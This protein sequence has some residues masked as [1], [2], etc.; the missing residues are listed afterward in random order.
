M[1]GDPSPRWAVA[2]GVGTPCL[3]GVE[4]VGGGVHQGQAMV[5]V[6]VVRGMR[7]PAEGVGEGEGGMRSWGPA[8]VVGEGVEGV[9]RMRPL[10]LAMGEGARWWSGGGEVQAGVG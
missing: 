3:G 6:G 8:G 10:C 7:A 1:E 5:G 2:V 4:V 9:W